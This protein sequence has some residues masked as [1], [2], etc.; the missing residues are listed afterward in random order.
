MLKNYMNYRTYVGVAS[1]LPLQYAAATAWN[2]EEHVQAS[3]KIYQENFKIAEEV[4]GIKPAEATFYL[5]I[6]VSDDE[7]FTAYLYENY[8][9]K[10]LPGSYLGRNGM[11]KGY[12]RIA[13]VEKPVK[14]KEAL[15]RLKEAMESFNG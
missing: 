12:I 7:A 10:A 14:T 11:G 3:R 5:W 8:S 6:A 9:V 1:P 13:L 4:L 15:T 2:E